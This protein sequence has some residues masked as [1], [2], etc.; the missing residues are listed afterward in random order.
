[1]RDVLLRFDDEAAAI[2]ALP[3]LHGDDGWAGEILPVVLVTAEPVYGEP[4]EGELPE[5]VSPREVEP[6]FWL[7]A[8]DQDLPGAVATIERVTGQIVSGDTSLAGARLEP[9]WAGAEPVLS[10]AA[11]AP[12]RVPAAISD[13]QFAQ[14]LAI[15]GTITEA[16][17][18]AWAARGELPASLDAAVD[19]LPVEDQF[20][21][22]MLLSS[23]TSYEFE[24]PLGA[25]LGPKLGFD[26][27]ARRQLWRAA[28]LL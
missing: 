17:A 4:A 24:H 15:L 21:A 1:M 22:R 11:P 25:K 8:P 14:Q 13:R 7:L 6:G 2:A 5:L 9:A 10:I 20:S 26:E 19:D 18:I 27:T 3:A 28:A 23:A 16:E 12:E